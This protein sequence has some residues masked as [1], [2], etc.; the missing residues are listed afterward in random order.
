MLY[1]TKFNFISLVIY[2]KIIFYSFLNKGDATKHAFYALTDEGDATKH[3][4]YTLTDEGDAI[5]HVF[6][7]LT[8]EG[9]AIKHAF[10]ALTDEGDATKHTFYALTDEVDTMK[11]LFI[12]KRLTKPITFCKPFLGSHDNYRLQKLLIII[13]RVISR[14]Y[15]GYFFSFFA[16]PCIADK[17]HIIII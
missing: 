3:V 16:L 14:L 10:Y 8:D 12:Q 11:H 4:F 5:K 7:T 13:N 2:L 9:D 15:V 17:L 6:Y 1:P